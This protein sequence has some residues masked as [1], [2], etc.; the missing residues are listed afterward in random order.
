[1]IADRTLRI[2]DIVGNTFVSFST[3]PAR[4]LHRSVDTNFRLPVGADVGKIV[5][6][7]ERRAGAVGP[8]HDRDRLAWQLQSRIQLFDSRVIPG[9][10]VA[11]ENLGESWPIEDEIAGL[12]ALKIDDRY[13]AAHHHRELSKA[14]FIELLARQRRV[15]G[16]EGNGLGFD[17]FNSAT[18]TD[19]LV[20]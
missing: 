6:K 19:R 20:V 16:S 5:S 12:H 13:D 4:P 18:G 14:G 9:L 10:D 15:A 2:A 1:D 17:L 8:M 3:D 7:V 11:E